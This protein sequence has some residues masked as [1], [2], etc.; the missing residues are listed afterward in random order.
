MVILLLM[1]FIFWVIPVFIQ[2]VSYC[3]MYAL[4]VALVVGALGL[5]RSPR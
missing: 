1:F 2:V 5:L 3:A 4:A